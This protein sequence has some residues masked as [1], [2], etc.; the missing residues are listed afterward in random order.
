[1][2]SII[3][4]PN[5]YV[6][7]DI[8]TTGLSPRW[9]DIL[10]LAAIKYKNGAEVAR[11]S[12]LIKPSQPIRPFISK[13]TGITNEMVQ[14]CPSISSEIAN[15]A[16]FVD[17]NVLVGHN[18][19]A[20]D[21]VFI[22]YAYEAYL[23]R[24]L[25]SQC[26][27]TLRL[28]KKLYPEIGSYTLSNLARLLDI[29]YLGAHR[30]LADC[31]ITNGCYQKIR[32]NALAAGTEE[33]FINIF[34]KKHSK[35]QV[36][37]ILPE[38]NDIDSNHPFY[39]KVIVF[40]GALRMPRAEAMQ[41]AVNFGAVLKTSVTKKTDFLVVGA[42]NMNRVGSDGLSSKEEKA[43]ALNTSGVAHIQVITE[44]DFLLITKKE[45]VCI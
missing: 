33:N 30:A 10:E 42:Q 5:D 43:I 44:D 26:I 18:I 35:I 31:E 28:C 14:G 34:K 24:T 8:E 6:V 19:A 22:S 15:F 32:S 38:T 9:E 36:K 16:T 7:V 45:R 40:T 3:A 17:D 23:H 11:Y 2:E 37:T 20:F 41:L 25:D 13:L 1:M 27:D 39:G 29:P 12:Q 21:T 4:L